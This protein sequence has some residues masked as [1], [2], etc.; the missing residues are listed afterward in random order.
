ML[1]KTRKKSVVQG[2]VTFLPYRKDRRH[3]QPDA[4]PD[5]QCSDGGQVLGFEAC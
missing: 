2:L 4:L 1:L 5:R 3:I